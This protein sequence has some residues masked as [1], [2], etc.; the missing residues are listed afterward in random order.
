MEIRE[1]VT[2]PTIIS[3]SRQLSSPS[4]SIIYIK[5]KDGKQKRGKCLTIFY[6]SRLLPWVYCWEGWNLVFVFLRVTWGVVGF[7]RFNYVVCKCSQKTEALGLCGMLMRTPQEVKDT[8]VMTERHSWHQSR[9]S[10][11]EKCECLLQYIGSQLNWYKSRFR[12]MKL[13]LLL[14]LLPMLKLLP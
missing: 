10:C 13:L 2:R 8:W 1:G 3:L 5:I 12:W 6:V 9:V 4:F 7:T 11:R 14:L